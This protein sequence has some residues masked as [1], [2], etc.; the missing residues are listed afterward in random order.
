MNHTQ[1]MK[2]R[3]ALLYTRV[4][5]EEQADRG[6]SLRDQEARLRQYCRREGIAVVGHYQD[7]HS[8][9]TF[10]RPAW[11]KLMAFIKANRGAADLLLVIKWDRFSRDATGALGMIRQLEARGVEVQAAEQPIDR[12]VPEQLAMLSLYV[13]LPQIENERRSLATR[14]GMRRA[15]KEGRY[16]GKAPKGYRNARDER[17]RK[18]IIPSPDAPF[19]QEAFRLAAL[20]EEMPMEELRRRLWKKGFRCSRNRFT[21]ILKNPVYAG[22]VLVPAYKDEPEALA[23]GVH[24]ALIP[25]SLYEKVQ[26]RFL[27]GSARAAKKRRHVEGLPLRGHLVCAECLEMG[28]AQRLTGSL[29]RSKTGRRYAYYHCHLCGEYRVRADA[30]NEAARRFLRSIQ[31]GPEVARLYQAVLDDLSGRHAQD[32]RRR[33]STLRAEV[34]ALEEKLFR[35]DEMFVEGELSADSYQRLKTRYAGD[36]VTARGQLQEAEEEGGAFKEHLLFAVDLFSRLAWLFQKSAVEVQHALLGSIC[37]G[38]LV[39]DGEKVR[40]LRP[41]PVIGL[42]RGKSQKKRDAG[43]KI[44]PASR[45]VAGAGF[46]PAT[47]GL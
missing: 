29:S 6:Y 26:S 11:K 25:W 4:S 37:P 24:E 15:L 39:F 34:E 2:V 18:I 14:A 23:D 22:K 41:S 19:V 32:R 28:R 43:R 47:F 27:A 46:E 33:A 36:L 10:E 30:A 20:H 7:D 44:R 42:F 3:R 35:V 8:A 5:T 17:N 21:Q 12:S 38:G 45:E 1:K 40:T 9:K 13:T 31:V 16:M